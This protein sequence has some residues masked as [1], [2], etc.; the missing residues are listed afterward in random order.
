M[1]GEKSA[2]HLGELPWTCQPQGQLQ[3]AQVKATDLRAGAALVLS[4][5]VAEGV[6]EIDEIYHIDRGYPQIEKDLV[7]LGA[8]IRRIES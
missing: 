7:G 3:G 6:T 5:L 4:G 8:R 2:G 1:A